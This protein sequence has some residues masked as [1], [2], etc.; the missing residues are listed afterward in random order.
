MR[1]RTL[2][3]LLSKYLPPGNYKRKAAHALLLP[4][5]TQ[6]SHRATDRAFQMGWPSQNKSYLT[7]SG[8]NDRTYTVVTLCWVESLPVGLRD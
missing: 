1:R 7:F 2:V 5:V 8:Q 3:W 4:R 6:C